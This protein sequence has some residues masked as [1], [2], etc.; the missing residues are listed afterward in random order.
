MDPT[1]I[2]FIA[3]T[4]FI[5]YRLY[6]VLGA[7]T[8]EER[9]R[10]VEGLQR[11]R[12]QRQERE[13]EDQAEPNAPA[14]LA[15][16]SAAAGPLRAADPAFDEKT[17]LDGARA[18]YELIVEAFAS[19]D[20]KS[21]RRFL[22][23]SVFEA[24]R[25]AVSARETAGQRSD[26]KFV[27]IDDAKIFASRVDDGNLVAVTDFRSN[28]VRTTYDKAGAVVAGDPARID[29]VR[30]RWTFTRPVNSSDPNWTLVA[31]GGA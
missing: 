13:V 19:G 29:L 30:D 10:D 22:S 17:F 4:A 11:A 3:L 12:Q 6:S 25:T 24:F 8:G 27:G 7:R 23:P 21:I 18:A 31:T 14:P 26:L 15:P 2:V 28:Q 1:L 20:L 5:A 16:V 9:Q